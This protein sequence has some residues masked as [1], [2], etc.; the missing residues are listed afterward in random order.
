MLV[1]TQMMEEA[2]DVLQGNTQSNTALNQ[3]FQLSIGVC[4]GRTWACLKF[5]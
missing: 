1:Y 5:W 3:A 4:P 2:K